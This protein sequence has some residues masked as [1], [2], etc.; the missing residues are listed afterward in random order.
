MFRFSFSGTRNIIF[1]TLKIGQNDPEIPNLEFES[2]G[3]LN[4][5]V[6]LPT[7]Q[8][9]TN[10]CWMIYQEINFKICLS[11]FR[12]KENLLYKQHI[13]QWWTNT[14]W[15][16]IKAKTAIPGYQGATGKKYKPQIAFN[17]F[18]YRVPQRTNMIWLT[19]LSLLGILSWSH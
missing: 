11:L 6:F 5:K 19:E 12:W 14:R 7:E 10:M 15:F 13:V 1:G 17:K 2:H 9:G 3:F 8:A 4:N 18:I 16:W